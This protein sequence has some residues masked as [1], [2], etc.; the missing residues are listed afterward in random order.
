MKKMKNAVK[1]FLLKHGNVLTSLAVL[2]AISTSEWCG[3]LFYQEE[4][5][6]GLK[7]FAQ[8][9]VKKDQQ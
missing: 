8:R 5:P 9:A 6:K 2:G 1:R 4:E 7:E 3:W